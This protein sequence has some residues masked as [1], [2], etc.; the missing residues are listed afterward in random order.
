MMILP[1]KLWVELGFNSFGQVYLTLCQTY[2][3]WVYLVN[4]E[5]TYGFLWKWND[6]PHNDIVGL[7]CTNESLNE[8]QI[9]I[10]WVKLITIMEFT[11]TQ[12]SKNYV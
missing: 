3:I 5:S 7:S 8:L 9:E 2:Q 6:N 4:C 1:K 12:L 10:K 11:K